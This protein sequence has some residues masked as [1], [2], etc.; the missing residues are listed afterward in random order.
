MRGPWGKVRM[1]DCEVP[2]AKTSKRDHLAQLLVV[3]NTSTS[4]HLASRSSGQDLSHPAF[5]PVLIG[6]RSFFC[7]WPSWPNLP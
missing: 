2:S 1:N 4:L 5:V 6:T 7:S 3:V